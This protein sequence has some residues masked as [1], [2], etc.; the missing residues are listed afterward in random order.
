MWGWICIRSSFW[1]ILL[2]LSKSEFLGKLREEFPRPKPPSS[3]GEFALIFGGEV[4][5][6]KRKWSRIMMESPWMF[7]PSFRA[8]SSYQLRFKKGCTGIFSNNIVSS[9]CTGWWIGKSYSHLCYTYTP[10]SQPPK[11]P[12]MDSPKGFVLPGYVFTLRNPLENPHCE[13]DFNQETPLRHLDNPVVHYTLAGK[14]KKSI[15]ISTE[16]PEKKVTHRFEEV[17][18]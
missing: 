14:K 18:V 6:I 10:Q 7:D 11:S 15:S 13:I 5:T 2:T 17:G 3:Q 16:R 9:S 1:Q 12:A 4:Y 8:F